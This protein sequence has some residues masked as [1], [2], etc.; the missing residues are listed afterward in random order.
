M[1]SWL[2]EKRCLGHES[3]PGSQDARIFAERREN[4]GFRRRLGSEAFTL[5]F[6]AAGQH[7]FYSYSGLIWDMTVSK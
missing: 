7:Q 1:F 4:T 6:L 5:T 2:T 3:C